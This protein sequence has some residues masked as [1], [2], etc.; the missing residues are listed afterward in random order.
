MNKSPLNITYLLGAGAS[1]KAL[2]LVKKTDEVDSI[3]QRLVH[4]KKQLEKLSGSYSSDH[5]SF[6]DDLKDKL[7]WLSEKT[8]EFG[9]PDTYAK[10]L[11]LKDKE[12]LRLLKRT[13]ATYFVFDQIINKRFDNRA[14]IFLTSILQHHM[15]FPESVNILSWNYDFQLQMAAEYFMQESFSINKTGAYT[16]SPPLI[17]YHPPVGNISMQSTDEISLVHLNGIAG[18]FLTN[19]HGLSLSKNVFNNV[20][21]DIN[22]ILS[23]LKSDEFDNGN[24][25]WFAWEKHNIS[26]KSIE[27]AKKIA[28][29]THVLVVI[30]YSFPFFNRE[31]DQQIFQATKDS[32]KLSKIYFQDPYASGDFLKNQFGLKDQITIKDIKSNGNY[33]IPLE[34]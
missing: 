10:F 3:P 26:S 21:P 19:N 25:L 22:S 27:Y 34:L 6:V 12:N 29:K 17:N 9:T 4:F 2:P 7:L 11:Y 1:A 32:D 28:S 16:H 31:I 24:L 5:K 18:A 8:M 14:L 33:F 30:G 15:R 23:T 20:D 13:L